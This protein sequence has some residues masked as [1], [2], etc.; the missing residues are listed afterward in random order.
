M[1]RHALVAA[2]RPVLAAAPVR[3]A[4]LFGSAA[5]D[6]R[7]ADSDVDVAFLPRDPTLSLAAELGLQADLHRAC[8]C[9]VDLVRID[10]ADLLLAWQIARHGALIHA[11]PPAEYARFVMRAAADYL[12]AEPTLLAA[13]R[14]YARRLAEA[15]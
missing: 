14:L 12:D 9:E 11:D 7:R 13:A 1:G 3:L 4:I 2:L 6:R 15:R 8:A 10:Q 5:R